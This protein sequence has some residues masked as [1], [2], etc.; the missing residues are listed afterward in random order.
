M[1]RS[2]SITYASLTTTTTRSREMAMSSVSDFSI[3]INQQI[4][5]QE[6]IEAYLWRL[7]ALMAVVT[8]N[9]FYD[10]P[11]HVLH[12]YFSIAD[13]LI[14]EAAKANQASINELLETKETS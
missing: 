12:N 8:M 7:E 6:R 10:L 13:D 1:T 14:G 9:D 5:V 11:K 2:A 3:F 4:R